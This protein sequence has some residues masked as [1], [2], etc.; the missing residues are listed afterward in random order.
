MIMAGRRPLF[1]IV[2]LSALSFL[3]VEDHPLYSPIVPAIQGEIPGLN[4]QAAIRQRV[5]QLQA[6]DHRPEVEAGLLFEGERLLAHVRQ[7]DIDR[8]A[9]SGKGNRV[10]A[11]A[12]GEYGDAL[13]EGGLDPLDAA[14]ETLVAAEQIGAEKSAFAQPAAAGPVEG[15]GVERTGP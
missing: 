14:L 5:G 12:G 11:V 2:V 4:A 3:S 7:R 10:A 15:Q 9:R 8:F 1:V 6:T 13:V